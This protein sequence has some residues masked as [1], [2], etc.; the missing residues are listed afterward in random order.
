MSCGASTAQLGP[1]L[2]HRD[3]R[4]ET[5]NDGE[6]VAPAVGFLAE[7]KGK[8]EIDVAAGSEDR[9]EIERRRQDAY[10]GDRL[11]VENERAADKSGVGA[12]A[13][14]PEAVAHAAQPWARAICIP[15]H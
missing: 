6:R 14:G 15:R 9:S 8:I 4:F 10:H 7:G 2:A 13:P 11:I 1:S 3:A 12:K 5:A